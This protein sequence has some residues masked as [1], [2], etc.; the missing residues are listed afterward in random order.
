MSERV[1]DPALHG[2]VR[3]PRP[4]AA[5][6]RPNS[7][8][9]VTC[10]D[11]HRPDGVGGDLEVHG[12]AWDFAVRGD[13]TGTVRESAT[14][15]ASVDY[16]GGR[17]LTSITTS[18]TVPGLAAA[19][20]S[21]AISGFRGRVGATGAVPRSAP[22]ALLLDDLPLG[23]LISGHAVSAAREQGDESV[24]AGTGYIPVADQ[25]AGYAEG[26]ALI[27]AIAVRGRG[28]VA[29]GPVAPPI[30]DAFG[31]TPEP[32]AVHSMRRRRRI[33]RWTEGAAVRI[34]AMF[35]DTYRGVDG[36]ET[37]IHEYELVVVAD[38]T[39][40]TIRAATATPRVLPWSD[41]PGAVASAGSLVGMTLDQVESR[42]RREL[43]GVRT[44][45]HLNDLL[46][47]IG[48]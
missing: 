44:C 11:L 8:R 17:T 20:G 31:W 29:Q 42:V 21:S 34:D 28:P 16:H 43:R 39:T 45:T 36:I 41:C 23:T 30:D 7:S 15:R 13:G 3:R 37:V 10:L 24:T 12:R 48:H 27:T 40:G 25:C 2:S 1:P 9:R 38:A 14:L 18:P 46:R 32:L 22:L 47:S 4:A 26:G 5:P 35:R 33:D 6:A 19:V